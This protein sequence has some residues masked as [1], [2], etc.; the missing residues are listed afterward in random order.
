MN[1]PTRPAEANIKDWRKRFLVTII[2]R[3]PALLKSALPRT[4]R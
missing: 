1:G 3:C 2:A 4:A